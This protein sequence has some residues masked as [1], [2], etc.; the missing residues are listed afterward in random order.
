M[1][2]EAANFI[3]ITAIN[4]MGVVGASRGLMGMKGTLNAMERVV[5]LP[6]Y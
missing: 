6:W 1:T 4:N 2:C 5:P 3:I